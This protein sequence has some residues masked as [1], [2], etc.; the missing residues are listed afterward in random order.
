[1]IELS[2]QEAETVLEH[3]LAKHGAHFNLIDTATR[4]NAF[5]ALIVAVNA[6]QELGWHV[7]RPLADSNGPTH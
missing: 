6:M 3:A 2:Q 1:M 4:F 5:G 7:A